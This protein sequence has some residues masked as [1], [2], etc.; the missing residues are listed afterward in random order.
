L[1]RIRN[2]AGGVENE[3]RLGIEFFAEL[4]ELVRAELVGVTSF[5]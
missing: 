1:Q 4:D 2:A 5:H 3:N